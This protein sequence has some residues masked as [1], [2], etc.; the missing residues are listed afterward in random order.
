MLNGEWRCSWSS[1]DR[2]WSNYIWVINNFIAYWGATY[3]R[4][5]TVLVFLLNLMGEP[6]NHFQSRSFATLQVRV[7]HDY[8]IFLNNRHN[9]PSRSSKI[10]CIRQISHNAPY[11]NRNVRTCAQYCYKML[12]C[13]MWHQCVMGFVQRVMTAR[14]L[15]PA[16]MVKFVLIAMQWDRNKMAAIMQTSCSNTFYWM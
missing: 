9:M 3:I 10:P 1:A 6:D 2:R 13:G 5:F 4:G 16:F 8:H 7:P 11:C 15:L 12:H 14:W